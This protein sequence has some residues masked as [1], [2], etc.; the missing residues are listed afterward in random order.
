MRRH[1]LAAMMALMCT[2]TVLAVPAYAY[3]PPSDDSGIS[4]CAEVVQWYYRTKN[5][6]EEMRLWSVTYQK[7]LTDW[8][9]VPNP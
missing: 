6:V 7:W 1:V 4:T 2:V 9:P 5:G 3:V 8:I